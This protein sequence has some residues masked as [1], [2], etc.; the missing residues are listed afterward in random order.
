MR[1]TVRLFL[2]VRVGRFHTKT[3]DYPAGSTVAHVAGDLSLPAGEVGLILVNDRQADLEH[4]LTDGD[5]VA[6][7]PVVGG[8]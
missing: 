3:F 1:I 8:G 7:F 4:Q 2:S 5:T 6:L